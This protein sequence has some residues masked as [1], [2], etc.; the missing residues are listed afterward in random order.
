[1]GITIR[2]AVISYPIRYVAP[3][4]IDTPRANTRCAATATAAS[5]CYREFL[6][7]TGVCASHR[8]RAFDPF[9]STA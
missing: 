8:V 9:S 4:L 1:V 6:V 2:S 5:L 7:R 3:D